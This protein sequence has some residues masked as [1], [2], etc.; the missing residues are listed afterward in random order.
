MEKDTVFYKLKLKKTT[1]PQEIFDKMLKALKKKGPTAKWQANVINEKQ[2]LIDFGDNESETFDLTFDEKGICDGFCKVCFSM[3]GEDFDD[4]KRSEFKAFLNMIYSTK[5]LLSL[6]EIKDDYGIA[7][8]FIDSKTNKILLREL[9]EQEIKYT[10][11]MFDMGHTEIREFVNSLLCLYRGLPYFGD[12]IPYI[13]KYMSICP[14]TLWNEM[15]D[16]MEFY[17]GFCDSFLC[18]R[19]EYKD[20]GRLYDVKEY[21]RDLS[22]VWFSAWAFGIGVSVV[23]GKGPHRSWDAKSAQVI[24]FYDN[25][26][27]PAYNAAETDFEKCVLTHRFIV[28]I[29]DY[30]GFR[31][32][33]PGN[34]SGDLI[35]RELAG[36]IRAF[37][38]D[39]NNK[40]SIARYKNALKKEMDEA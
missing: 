25:K 31:H 36:A 17:L 37:L 30:L 1:K 22:A 10:Q 27:L 20:Q 14:M 26:Y 38:E 35:S 40:E 9:T 13:N 28:S 33:G 29:M 16:E 11:K 32:V 23:T 7:E 4:E 21:Y 6:M 19:T 24:R 18:E 34:L 2:L 15:S 12:Y 5:S 8:S 3:S 39:R